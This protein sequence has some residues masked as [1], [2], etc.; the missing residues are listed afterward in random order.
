MR[1]IFLFVL[2]FI[3]FL[4]AQIENNISVEI[5]LKQSENSIKQISSK[6]K[7]LTW[8]KNF[9]RAEFIRYDNDL[10]VYYDIQNI[11]E[12]SIPLNDISY[13]ISESGVAFDGKYYQTLFKKENTVVLDGEK[14]TIDEYEQIQKSKG[15]VKYNGKWMKPEVKKIYE[16]E[17]RLNAQ[18]K[19]NRNPDGEIGVPYL[20]LSGGIRTGKYE[21][22]YKSD[23]LS[24]MKIDSDWDRPFFGAGILLPTSPNIT[25]KL[26]YTYENL[27]QDNGDL[28]V[29]GGDNII[30]LSVKIKMGR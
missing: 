27:K 10:L 11:S 3:S 20:L 29:K 15:L 16:I 23:I 25:L 8:D 30:G 7:I 21:M 12:A 22:K 13:L 18:E 2:L 26:S 1:R 6:I 19:L 5:Y 4:F 17:R 9:I 14:V 24:N 28:F